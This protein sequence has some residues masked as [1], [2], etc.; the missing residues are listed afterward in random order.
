MK[1]GSLRAASSSADTTAPPPRPI[2]S[3]ASRASRPSTRP[4]LFETPVGAG[5]PPFSLPC[6]PPAPRRTARAIAPGL[7]SS[8]AVL[9]L[10]DQPSSAVD[11]CGGN[12]DGGLDFGRSTGPASAGARGPASFAPRGACAASRERGSSEG[13][14]DGS[15]GPGNG[16]TSMASVRDSGGATGP[17]RARSAPG[18]EA[19]NA[20][21]APTWT[22]I[23]MAEGIQLRFKVQFLA[24]AWLSFACK[25]RQGR[26]AIPFSAG[27]RRGQSTRCARHRWRPRVCPLSPP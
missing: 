18:S 1:L 13:S 11:P 23:A 4:P 9:G 12:P 14:G 19:R 8:G 6:S 17:G 25:G 15:V 10:N 27:R 16:S 20:S 21:S 24:G 26:A 7:V 22:A 2:P 3:S 5:S